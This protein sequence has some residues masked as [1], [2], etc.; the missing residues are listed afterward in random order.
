MGLAIRRLRAAAS[1]CRFFPYETVDH[2]LATTDA[3]MI[4]AKPARRNNATLRAPAATAPGARSRSST[5]RN[6]A[7]KNSHCGIR[8]EPGALGD[9]AVAPSKAP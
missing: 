4:S 2:R 3:T 9:G 6:S 7:P 5:S 8:R 1:A